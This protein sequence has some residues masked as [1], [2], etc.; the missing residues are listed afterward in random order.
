[1]KIALAQVASSSRPEENLS[2]ARTLAARA[3]QGRAEL[4]I[5]PEM[6]M[7]LPRKDSPPS[8]S[9]EKLDGPFAAALA[10]LAE[11]Y[12]I[13]ILAGVWEKIPEQHRVYNSAI[14]LAPK[15]NVVAT[16][17]KL[18]LFDAL[19]VQES[20]TMKAGSEV[21]PLVQIGGFTV[22]VAICYDL[23]FPE[24]FRQLAHRGADLILVPSAW[25]A[26]PLKEDHWLTLLR[27]RAIENTCYVAG[28]NQSGSAFCGR[29]VVFDPFGVPL[30]DAGEGE[31]LL[32]VQLEATRLAEVREKLP[33]LKHIRPELFSLE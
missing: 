12:R 19:K 7:A 15:G 33:S 11:T 9:A 8:A 4:L 26:G 20:K 21:P 24:L 30:A 23:R 25:Y 17:R 28:V 27:A 10:E 29:S 32:R 31:N 22:G 5:F 18:H 2:K 6:F 16:Y 3:A 13:H 1:M 14:L